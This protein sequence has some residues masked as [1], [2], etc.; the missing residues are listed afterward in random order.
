MQDVWVDDLAN[1][2]ARVSVLYT[3]STAP[4][5]RGAGA[6]VSKTPGGGT[7]ALGALSPG[8]LALGSASGVDCRQ[9]QLQRHGGLWQVAGVLRA[10]E[11]G[12]ICKSD[13]CEEPLDAL[14]ASA[15]GQLGSSNDPCMQTTACMED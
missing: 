5:S 15:S 8:G 7:L 4:A 2:S 10:D 13:S 9:F 3:S 1:D 11:Q 6:G 12:E 14:L